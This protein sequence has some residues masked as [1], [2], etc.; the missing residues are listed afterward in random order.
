VGGVCFGLGD[1]LMEVGAV[2]GPQHSRRSRWERASVRWEALQRR[3]RN[4][5]ASGRRYCDMGGAWMYLAMI[6][7]HV[8]GAGADMG[9]IRSGAG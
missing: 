9:G 8:E 6:V 2:R 4:E 1:A 5:S 3:G 7:D